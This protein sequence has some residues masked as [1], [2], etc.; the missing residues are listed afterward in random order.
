MFW[1][2]N[3]IRKKFIEFFYM[4]YLSYIATNEQALT[5]QIVSYQQLES[6]IL[7][8]D[9]LNLSFQTSGIIYNLFESLARC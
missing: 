2:Q 8:S 1:F 9:I 7:L 5:D 4:F 3:I 6:L